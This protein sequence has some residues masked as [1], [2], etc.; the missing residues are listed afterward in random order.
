MATP[1]SLPATFVAGNVLTA[2]QMNDLRGAFRILQIV[3][4]NT[5]SAVQSTSATPSDTGVTVN[6]TPSAT[7]NKVLV[8][9]GINYQLFA[10]NGTFADAKFDLLRDATTLDTLNLYHYQSGPTGGSGQIQANAYMSYLDTPS[11]T[12]ALTYK[13]QQA[14]ISAGSGRTIGLLGT[15]SNIVAMEVSA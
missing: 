4:G 2:A 12:S 3:E 14:I 11:S 10:N 5:S 6:I 7:S 1:T 9:V 15:W 8:F 13:V